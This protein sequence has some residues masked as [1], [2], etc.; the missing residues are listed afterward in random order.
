MDRTVAPAEMA[1]NP[2]PKLRLDHIDGIRATAALVVFIN[3]A[4]AQ[5]YAHVGFPGG[6]LSIF[7]YS[8]VAGHLAV[9]VFIVVS[10]FCLALPVISHG[11]EIPGGAK[12]FIRRRA[13]RLL[14]P[15]YAAL[16]LSLGLVATVIGKPTGTLWDVPIQVDWVAIVSHFLLLQDLFGTGRINYVFWSIAVEWQI[17]FL[18]PLIVWGW[19]RFGPLQVVLATLVLGYALRFGFWDTRIARAAPHFVGM[20]SL[21]MLAAYLARSPEA[22][23]TRWAERIPWSLVAAAGLAVA[24]AFSVYWGVSVSEGRFHYLDFPV[25]I[26]AFAL[27]VDSSQ[28][29]PSMLTRAFSFRPLVFIGTFSYSLYLVH[30]P[31]LQLLWQYVLN[32]LGLKLSVMFVLLLTAGL[33]VVLG[34]AYLFFRVFEAPFLGSRARV[35]APRTVRSV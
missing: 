9:T 16:V 25:G 5:V 24:M 13:R 33:A 17:Y 27:L 2:V 32:P 28:R 11:G 18:M 15:Y 12:E 8:M 35:R 19:R 31:L 20:F 1:G 34:V 10:G 3:H 29:R 23:Y 7:R 4:F 26:M 22:R 30:A 14:P 21:G 6:A